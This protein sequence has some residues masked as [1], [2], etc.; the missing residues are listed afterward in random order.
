MKQENIVLLLTACVNPNGMSFTF[1]NDQNE[2]LKQYIDSLKWYLNNT[3]FKILFVEN[4]NFD[5]SGLFKNEI[6]TGRLECLTFEGNNFD[7]QLGKGYGEAMILKY[8]LNNSLMLKKSTTI[9]KITGRVVVKNIQNLI[10]RFNDADTVYT[11][12][13][14]LKSDRN[15]LPSVFVI[16]P[17]SFW[18]LFLNNVNYINDSQN[19]YFEHVLKYT[20]D[21][22]IQKQHKYNIISLPI[23]YSGIS[24]STGCTYGRNF[25]T[26][27]FVCKIILYYVFVKKYMFNR[28]II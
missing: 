17:K 24:G 18:F 15:K 2:R 5:I 28:I 27:R 26:F 16:A 10:N 7:R 3:Y 25:T 11:D 19:I 6:Q 20:V 4:T 21:Y 13:S 22:W 14:R 9:V 23:H 1:L 12:F 8:A